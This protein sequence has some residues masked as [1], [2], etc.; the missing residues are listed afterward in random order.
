[1][2]RMDRKLP[3]TA[4]ADAPGKICRRGDLAERLLDGDLPD[5]GSTDARPAARSNPRRPT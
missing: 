2:V 5:R 3:E 4:V 1:M